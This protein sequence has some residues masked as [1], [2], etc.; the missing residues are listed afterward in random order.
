MDAVGPGVV[1]VEARYDG[2]K[3]RAAQP[4]ADDDG[5][6]GD[7][8]FP[9]GDDSGIPEIFRRFF[10]P[11]MPGATPFRGMPSPSQRPRGTSLGS[12]FIVSGDGYVLTNAHVVDGADKVTVKLSDGREFT[13]KTVGTDKKS[14]I[15]LLKIEAS[16]LPALRLGDSK[17]L[18]PGQWVVA[19]GSP[20]GLDHSVTAGI[21]SAVG[22]S[23]GAAQQ[24]VPFI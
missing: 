14:D 10:G 11:D 8:G 13:G 1:N 15:A 6:D 20:F 3:A 2:S 16:G 21:V 24:Y 19:I 7:N 22:R 17:D 23:A 12:G 5:S 9:G 4:A 18:K